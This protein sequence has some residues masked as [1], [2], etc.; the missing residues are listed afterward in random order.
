ML[1]RT[2]CA[3]PLNEYQLQHPIPSQLL[4]T[5]QQCRDADATAIN[6]FNIP[7][8]VLM[9]N[10]GRSCVERLMWHHPQGKL[11]ELAVLVLCGP[12]N[13]GGDG[14]VMARHLY[15]QGVPVKVVLLAAVESYSGD[16]LANLNSLSRLRLNVI[17]FDSNWKDEKV[18]SVFSKAKRRSVNWIVDAMLGTGAKGQ[19]RSAMAK[20]IRAANRSG[21][22]RLAVDIPTGFDCDTGALSDPTFRADLTCTFIDQKTG[23]GSDTAA[24]VLGVVTVVDIGAPSEIIQID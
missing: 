5:R 13:N 21:A 8:I 2:A 6:K 3:D 24:E 9:E 1:R 12:G 17:E 23:F 16:A 15:N 7:S 18:D 11:D 4:L 20:A 14:F 19:P 22:R 10:A